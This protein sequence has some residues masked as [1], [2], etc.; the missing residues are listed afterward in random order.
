MNKYCISSMV[1]SVKK[2]KLN[3]N[4]KCKHINTKFRFCTNNIEDIK[5]TNEILKTTIT[6]Y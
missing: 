4:C 3:D 2:S 1:T 5:L 6:F